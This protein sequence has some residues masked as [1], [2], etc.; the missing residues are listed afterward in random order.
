MSQRT[1]PLSTRQ[2]CV[3]SPSPR[4]TTVP[5]GS[6][7]R[8]SSTSRSKQ[9]TRSACSWACA[10]PSAPNRSSNGKSIR[11]TSSTALGSMSNASGRRASTARW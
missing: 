4:Q 5:R 10:P 3:S 6:R 8:K 7:A 11:S 9:P 1:R 2:N